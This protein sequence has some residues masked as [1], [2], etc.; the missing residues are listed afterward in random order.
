[1]ELLIGIV[2]YLNKCLIV[3]D[4]EDLLI[5]N[6]DNVIRSYAKIKILNL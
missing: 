6:S 3:N 5:L 1:M 2:K 4:A